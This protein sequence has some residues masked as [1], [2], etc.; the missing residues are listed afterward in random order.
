MLTV[1]GLPA[2]VVVETARGQSSCKTVAPLVVV[3]DV[4]PAPAASVSVVAVVMT[5]ATMLVVSFACGTASQM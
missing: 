3:T 4:T 1:V 5:A 2:P